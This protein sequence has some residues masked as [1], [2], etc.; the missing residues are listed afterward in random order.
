MKKQTLLSA[1]LLSGAM[2]G[3][4]VFSL[5]YAFAQLGLARG[6]LWLIFFAWVMIVFHLM[7]ADILLRTPGKHNFVSLAKIY[8]GDLGEWVGFIL[9]VV[10]MVLI[11]VIYLILFLRFVG[12]IISF[13]NPLVEL[14]AVLLFWFG[15]SF[16]IYAGLKQLALVEAVTSAAIAVVVALIFLYGLPNIDVVANLQPVAGGLGWVVGPLLFALS[17]RAAVVELVNYARKQDVKKVI[18]GTVI[19]VAIFYFLFVLGVLALTNGVVSDDTVSGLVGR[20]PLGSIVFISLMGLLAL[21]HAYTIIGFDIN[22]IL[23]VD[24]RWPRWLG[25]IVVVIL[26]IFIYLSGWRDFFGLVS[27]V[28]GSFL[29]AE[30]IFVGAMWLKLKRR[31]SKTILLKGAP[32]WWIYLPIVVFALVFVNQLTI[33]FLK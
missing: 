2:V 4:G 17:G 11:M 30:G 31:G 24:F 6:I 25:L 18:V 7:Y 22:N 16:A 8:L 15:G 26:P 20:L 1:G 13:A 9:T 32:G 14:A 12:L 21:W 29:A 19:T 5:P 27:L 33:Q 28:G 23:T 3:A 10:Q